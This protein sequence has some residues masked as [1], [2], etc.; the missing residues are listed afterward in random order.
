MKTTIIV[1]AILALVALGLLFVLA[2]RLETMRSK[3][4]QIFATAYRNNSAERW[5]LAEWPENQA[6]M[7]RPG[8]QTKAQLV[9]PDEKGNLDSCYMV[10]A[11]L[12]LKEERFGTAYV[13]FPEGMKE[14]P[15]LNED[16]IRD[17]NGNLYV[18][19]KE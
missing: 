18:P 3:L 4:D 15:A 11:D 19:I 12:L 1:I 10:P 14:T 2:S 6:L 7:A 16:C 8:F 9:M 5:Y 13:Q 17:Y